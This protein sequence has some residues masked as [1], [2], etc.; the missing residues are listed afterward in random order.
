M[1]L[2]LK[3]HNCDPDK[4]RPSMTCAAL[5]SGSGEVFDPDH[6]GTQLKPGEVAFRGL[7]VAGRDAP[8]RLELV[9][10]ALDGVPLCRAQRR[11][12]P[13]VPLCAP[14]SSGWRPGPV[15]PG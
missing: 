3:A 14:S 13:G 8:P 9:D 2:P 6:R 15:S 1:Q 10:Q 11:G 12:R 7:V 4:L 5:G